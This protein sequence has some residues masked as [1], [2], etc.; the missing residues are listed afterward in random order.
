[1]AAQIPVDLDGGADTGGGDTLFEG[2]TTLNQN[3]VALT[4]NDSVGNSGATQ[5]GYYNNNTAT[6]TTVQ[7]ALDN[8]SYDETNGVTTATNIG[9]GDGLIDSPAKVANVI[10]VKSLI[11][12]NN[13][14]FDTAT[15]PDAIQINSGL[16][17]SF[18]VT[19]VDTG[20]TYTT[21]SE[22][23]IILIDT[24]DAAF[25][26]TLQAGADQRVLYIKNLAWS[27]TAGSETQN[28][29]EVTINAATSPAQEYI[30]DDRTALPTT[31]T[32][33]GP[34]STMKVVFSTSLNTWSII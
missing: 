5:I 22:D 26:L 14:T 23:E 15:D 33:I 12:G 16:A 1:M 6:P 3:M 10:Q 25:T 32:A 29:T 24:Q 13:V 8:I 7:A 31:S 34:G 4:D 11:A 27:G 17:N 2:F 18:N 9:G 19:V 28:T 20:T 30:E 21:E